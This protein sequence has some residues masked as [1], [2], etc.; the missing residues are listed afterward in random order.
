MARLLGPCRQIDLI[1]AMIADHRTATG[2]DQASRVDQL[3]RARYRNAVVMPEVQDLLAKK[4]PQRKNPLRPS[5]TDHRNSAGMLDWL[6]GLGETSRAGRASHASD[7]EVNG[8]Q[9]AIS[10]KPTEERTRTKSDGDRRPLA[11]LKA[12]GV[13]DGHACVLGR[14]V[15]R[16][17]TA[18]GTDG[19]TTTRTAS[20][21]ARQ[22]PG[23]RRHGATARPT[24]RLLRPS[25]ISCTA[26]FHAARHP[27]LLG[28]DHERSRTVIRPRF[29]VNAVAVCGEEHLA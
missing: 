8:D 21:V 5:T 2:A 13:L 4:R 29:R 14:R 3:V 6:G 10:I 28:I 17:P 1:A 7:G 11:D 18:Q 19:A 23:L 27:F 20:A 22:A 16:R 24:I 9:L 12:R 15:G 25:K 26:R